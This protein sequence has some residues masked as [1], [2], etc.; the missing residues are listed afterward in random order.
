MAFVGVE[1]GGGETQLLEHA[2]LMLFLL[3][4]FLIEI[5][6]FQSLLWTELCQLP[7][8]TKL[9]VVEL[10]QERSY[11]RILELH[12]LAGEHWE[13]EQ[14]GHSSGEGCNIHCSREFSSALLS[15]AD[16]EP[17]DSAGFGMLGE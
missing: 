11:L 6:I 9:A 16:M 5:T 4:S 3:L 13:A 12:G 10:C 17:W 1:G 14:V 7:S 2:C 15:G 8:P